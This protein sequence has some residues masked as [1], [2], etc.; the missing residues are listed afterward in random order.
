MFQHMNP[1]LIHF[2][3]LFPPS[4]IAN[5]SLGSIIN[6]RRL[7][8][9]S[10]VYF[11][12]KLHGN[13]YVTSHIQGE[14]QSHR[15]NLFSSLSSFVTHFLKC[16]WW[17]SILRS[18]F[19]KNIILRYKPE[20]VTWQYFKTL[21]VPKKRNPPLELIHHDSQL[22]LFFFGTVDSFVRSFGGFYSEFENLV[23][24]FW[25]VSLC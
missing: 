2:L 21:T 8:N 20:E 5:S 4:K 23:L 12:T 19:V 9:W 1:F 10:F 25:T 7:Q 6:L 13:V 16:S 14:C 24:Q 18:S 17:I 11:K 3:R 15:V 22:I